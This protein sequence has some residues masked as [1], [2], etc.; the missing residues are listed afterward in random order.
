M[1]RITADPTNSAWELS[2][3]SGC[4]EVA[5]RITSRSRALP[6]GR[7]TTGS[8]FLVRA[9]KSKG[10]SF[11]EETGARQEHHG[12]KET[13]L[14]RATGTNEG[15]WK[16]GNRFKHIKGHHSDSRTTG[17]GGGALSRAVL[18]GLSKESPANPGRRTTLFIGIGRRHEKSISSHLSRPNSP[19][20]GK[21]A[22]PIRRK[23]GRPC[24]RELPTS[25]M[26]A[27]G[28]KPNWR[29]A[30]LRSPQDTSRAILAAGTDK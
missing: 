4:R 15:D 27:R 25:F 17:R 28:G 2:L 12:S 14:G 16:H 29:R 7:L 9:R 6:A 5:A 18:N 22:F 19:A 1:P 30:L 13:R 24:N 26:P 21:G 20:S 3:R 23:S 8:F 11:Y 10:Q